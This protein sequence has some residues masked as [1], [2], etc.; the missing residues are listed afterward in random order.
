MQ[1]A[2]QENNTVILLN[3]HEDPACSDETDDRD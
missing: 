1:T 3:L 2:F